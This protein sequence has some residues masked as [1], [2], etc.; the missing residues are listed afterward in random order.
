[1]RPA[2]RHLR[3]ADVG[4]LVGV[5]PDYVFVTRFPFFEDMIDDIGGITV[6]NP[7][8]FYDPYLKKEGFR[9]GRIHL[10]DDGLLPFL[11]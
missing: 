8:R 9:K 3:P 1:M 10:G 6:T 5:Q 2:A 4:D 7:R 11:Q